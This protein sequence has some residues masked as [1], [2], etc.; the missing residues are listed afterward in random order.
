M[1]Y[2]AEISTLEAARGN[3]F[4]FIEAVVKVGALHRMFLLLSSVHSHPSSR[5][6]RW[7]T[8]YSRDMASRVS[9]LTCF[10]SCLAQMLTSSWP[11]SMF[12]ATIK[13]TEV[14]VC[15]IL[16][17]LESAVLGVIAANLPETRRD[18]KS[19]VFCSGKRTGCQNLSKYLF[20]RLLTSG[21]IMRTPFTSFGGDCETG[22]M[23]AKAFL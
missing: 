5:S 16:P 12:M 13:T 3:V 20:Q 15:D 21:R 7:L 2:R 17:L 8:S 19:G 4:P 18:E 23:A 9:F 10:V 22:I 14:F 6:N 11:Q 1:L